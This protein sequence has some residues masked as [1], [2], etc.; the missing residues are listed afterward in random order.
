[1]A[2][3]KGA[4]LCVDDED[5]PRTLRRLILLTQGYEVFAAASGREALQMLA[6]RHF[7]LVLTDH[8]MPSM[9][10]TDLTR[11][12]KST[13]P[14]MP[15]IIISGVNEIPTDVSYADLF[16]SKIEGPQ[17]LFDGI[18]QVLEQYRVTSE[19]EIPDRQA[20]NPSQ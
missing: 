12:I 11:H 4:I 19:T 1:M 16:I 3:N 8:V 17:A 20:L 2:G 18:A 7:D 9:T 14:R 10:G 6:N 13:M 15:V 5:A